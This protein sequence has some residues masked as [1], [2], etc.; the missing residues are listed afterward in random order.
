MTSLIS[1]LLPGS[2]LLVVTLLGALPWQTLAGHAAPTT[3]SGVMLPL[4]VVHTWGFWRPAHLPA[5]VVFAAGLLADA[6]TAGPLGYWP[7]IYLIGLGLARFAGGQLHASLATTGWFAGWLSFCCGSVVIASAAWAT[8][9]LYQLQLISWL[10]LAWPLGL[11][12]A[13]YP[14]LAAVLLLLAHWADGDR[15]LR[16]ARSG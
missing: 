12:L 7:L 15:P 16:N 14:V 8:S 13:A 11:T 2:V 6:L 1:R 10:A 3:S 5:W 4:A 9:S